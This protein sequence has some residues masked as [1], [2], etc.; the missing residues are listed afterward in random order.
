MSAAPSPPLAEAIARANLGRE[1]IIEE[2]VAA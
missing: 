1:A 2:I